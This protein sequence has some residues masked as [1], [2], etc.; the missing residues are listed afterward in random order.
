MAS[1]ERTGVEMFAVGEHVLAIQ[2]HP[3]FFEDVV[4]DLLDHRLAPLMTVGLTPSYFRFGDVFVTDGMSKSTSYLL[5]L[6]CV[7]LC[8]A[9]RGDHVG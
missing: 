9:E 6:Y 3:E 8:C 7:R 1:S 5:T 2:G 4:V